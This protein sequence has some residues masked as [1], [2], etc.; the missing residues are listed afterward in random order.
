MKICSQCTQELPFSAFYRNN[1]YK[2]GY[3]YCCKECKKLRKN[4]QKTRRPHAKTLKEAFYNY[5][6]PL[7]PDVC[8][9]WQGA[10][11]KPS[12][13]YYYGLLRFKYKLLLAHR[14]SWEVHNGVIGDGLRVLHSCDNPPCVNPH[15]L[16]LGTALDNTVDGVAKGRIKTWAEKLAK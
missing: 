14:V 9:E 2:D 11:M 10:R 7:T 1:L 16:S 12:L 15:H 3:E 13:P 4:N 8:W 5:V 6:T